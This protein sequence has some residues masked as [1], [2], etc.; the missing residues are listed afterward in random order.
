MPANYLN[1]ILFAEPEANVMHYQVLHSSTHLMPFP[2][3]NFSIRYLRAHL[4]QA[5]QLADSTQVQASPCKILN[6][7]TTLYR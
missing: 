4:D 6:F 2:F 3:L 5:L 7:V 1:F